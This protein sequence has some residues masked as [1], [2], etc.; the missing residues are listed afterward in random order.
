MSRVEAD[1][2]AST[3]SHRNDAVLVGVEHLAHLSHGLR[4]GGAGREV[5]IP[6]Q[7]TKQTPPA[8]V[9]LSRVRQA[10]RYKWLTLW[11]VSR[12]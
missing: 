5:S 10:P 2:G 3:L 8:I 1:L 11:T 7:A 4:I 9:S 12:N 6:I